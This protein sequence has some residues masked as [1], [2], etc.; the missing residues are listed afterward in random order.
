M[1]L[2]LKTDGELKEKMKRDTFE[3]LEMGFSMS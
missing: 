2:Y 3:V 1:A